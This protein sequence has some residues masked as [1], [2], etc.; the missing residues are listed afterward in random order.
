MADDKGRDTPITKHVLP[1][2]AEGT[3]STCLIRAA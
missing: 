3:I 2:V 1:V